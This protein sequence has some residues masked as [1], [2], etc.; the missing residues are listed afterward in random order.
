[1]RCR[2]SK[3]RL[4]PALPHRR[5]ETRRAVGD[6]GVSRPRRPASGGRTRRSP[7]PE[8]PRCCSPSSRPGR[9]SSGRRCTG[10]PRSRTE[11]GARRPTARGFLRS[12]V[13]PSPSWPSPLPPQQSAR[14]AAVTPQVWVIPA[15][16][17][18][19][20]G[21]VAVAAARSGEAPGVRESGA[22]GE[23]AFSPQPRA[24]RTRTGAAR[25][26][27][28]HESR[29]DRKWLPS[30]FD[31]ATSLLG[32]GLRRLIDAYPASSRSQAGDRPCLAASRAPTNK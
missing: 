9:S 26:T 22:V 4:Q 27:V 8:F 12:V 14:S 1:M 15:L 5:G 18:T 20:D 32:R 21:E 3:R 7:R 28:R 24:A 2:P 6:T 25:R 31:I 30:G 11:S 13:V 23:S 17:W 10:S 29:A 16:T 19:N